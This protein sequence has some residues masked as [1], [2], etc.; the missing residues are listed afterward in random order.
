MKTSLALPL[1]RS[2]QTPALSYACL[3]SPYDMTTFTPVTSSALKAS[4]TDVAAID[5]QQAKRPDLNHQE[6]LDLVIQAAWKD[7]SSNGAVSADMLDVEL[8]DAYVCPSF[9]V[10]SNSCNTAEPVFTTPLFSSACRTTCG[11][12]DCG[13][14]DDFCGGFVACGRVL[15]RELQVYGARRF[16]RGVWGGGMYLRMLTNR[17]HVSRRLVL[18]YVGHQANLLVIQ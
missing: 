4:M 8:R 16:V 1:T 14:M 3:P 6:I 2:L 10:T 11:A 12:R 5:E 7:A 17:S 13:Y 15:C 9:N 18:P